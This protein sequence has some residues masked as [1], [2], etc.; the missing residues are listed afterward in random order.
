[1]RKTFLFCATAGLAFAAIAVA[2]PAKASFDLIRW[3][4][5]GFCQVWDRS[6]SDEPYG[7]YTTVAGDMPTF[8]TALFEKDGLLSDGTCTY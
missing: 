1:M 4:N 5:T 7:D 3:E 8:E 6:I 2:S